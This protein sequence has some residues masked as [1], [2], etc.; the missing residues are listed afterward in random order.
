MS[1]HA[2]PEPSPSPTEKKEPRKVVTVLAITVLISMTWV[3]VRIIR[4][5]IDSS[6]NE[7]TQVA[8]TLLSAAIGFATV[9]VCIRLWDGR[10][11][12]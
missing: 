12:N 1:R 11:G 5:L 10:H 6:A 9:R 8:G 4:W 7:H 2:A 3:A